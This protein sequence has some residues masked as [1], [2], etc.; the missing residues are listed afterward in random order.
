[1]NAQQHQNFQDFSITAFVV[2]LINIL[3]IL[4]S[5]TT[6]F[7]IDNPWPQLLFLEIFKQ[8]QVQLLTVI[9]TPMPL[10][11]PALNVLLVSLMPL[12]LHLYALVLLGRVIA[13]WELKAR[14]IY[15][16]MACIPVFGP[17]ATQIVMKSFR[18]F[19]E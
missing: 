11:S 13:H 1:M 7:V 16:L 17:I 6:H 15:V 19:K 12:L 14:V 10:F 3:V 9:M 2:L 4:L 5:T 18:E 8:P